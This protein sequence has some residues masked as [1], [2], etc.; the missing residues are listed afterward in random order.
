MAITT[1]TQFE[2]YQA[3]DGRFF[4][5]IEAKEIEGKTRLAGRR[6]LDISGLAVMQ[7]ELLE[8]SGLWHR[9]ARDHNGV[10]A[11]YR[12][13]IFDTKAQL[14]AGLDTE[15]GYLSVK[16]K[17]SSSYV[18]RAYESLRWDYSAKE[19]DRALWIPAD[20]VTGQQVNLLESSEEQLF[21]PVIDLRVKSSSD[22][23]VS[24]FVAPGEIV[25]E[26]SPGRWYRFPL[27]STVVTVYS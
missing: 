5:I 12:E 9:I 19:D 11:A 14:E 10:A 13:A 17:T 4:N 22:P 1:G 15:D 7:T 18:A 6:L 23:S 20:Q 3:A 24:R 26:A 21:N 2:Q 8:L 27:S 16:Q 25:E